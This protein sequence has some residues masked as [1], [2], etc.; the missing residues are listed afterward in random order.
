[1]FHGLWT[2]MVSIVW[3][4][5]IKQIIVSTDSWDFILYALGTAVGSIF[6]TY[7]HSKFMTKKEKD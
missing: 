5:L 1:M 4:F 3:V 7:I 2:F 6:A